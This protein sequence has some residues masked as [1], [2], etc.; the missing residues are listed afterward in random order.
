MAFEQTLHKQSGAIGA[1]I[2]YRSYFLSF[3]IISSNNF[4]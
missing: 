2:P 4:L 1:V 3:R